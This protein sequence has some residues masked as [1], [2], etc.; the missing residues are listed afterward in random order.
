MIRSNVKRWGNS[1]AIRIPATLMQALDLN[2]DDEIKIDLIEGKLV[3]EPVKKEPVFTLEELVEG[4]SPDNLHELV[5]WGD[6]KG[7]ETW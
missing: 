3:I 5:D 4:I 7:K 2:I 6:P 1:P